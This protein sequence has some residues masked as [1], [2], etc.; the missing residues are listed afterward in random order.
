MMR[1]LVHLNLIQ[2]WMLSKNSEYVTVTI[3]IWVG[4]ILRYFSLSVIL[5]THQIL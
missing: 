4:I 2:I 5:Q 3:I 1:L